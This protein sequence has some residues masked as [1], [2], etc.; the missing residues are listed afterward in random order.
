MPLVFTVVAFSIAAPFAWGAWKRY[1][2]E[3]R[4][5]NAAAATPAVPVR[6]RTKTAD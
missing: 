4:E 2:N 1:A 6:K 3:Q 5:V